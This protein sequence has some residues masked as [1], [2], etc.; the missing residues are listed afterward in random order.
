LNRF[1]ARYR[2]WSGQSTTFGKRMSIFISHELGSIIRSKWSI[3]VL[4]LTYALI[5]IPRLFQAMSPMFSFEPE[6]YF[7]L[8]SEMQLFIILYAAV[9]GSGIIASDFQNRSIV[10]YLTKGYSRAGY[11]LGKFIILFVAFSLITILPFIMI[12]S[13]ALISSDLT[14]SL[15]RNNIWLL[16][17]GLATGTTIT[18]FLSM[19]TAGLSALLGDRRYTGAAL[20]ALMVLSG[21]VS[22]ILYSINANEL[23]FLASLW[24][25]ID[26]VGTYLFR[27]DNLYEFTRFYPFLAILSISLSMGYIVYHYIFRKEIVA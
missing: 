16:G 1:S 15:L 14:F 12:Y 9:V 3:L 17:A 10:L 22:N 2:P 21:I 7:S 8:F 20:F 27:L 11:V 26:L 19:L 23:M 13:I 5:V 4:I 6:F 24:Q 18:I 25:N